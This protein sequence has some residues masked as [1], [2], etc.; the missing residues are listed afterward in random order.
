MNL[1]WTAAIEDGTYFIHLEELPQGLD[2]IS[3]T[4]TLQFF[5]VYYGAN[6][7]VHT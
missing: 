6:S 4:F 2:Y 5:V 1:S 3:K 7:Y